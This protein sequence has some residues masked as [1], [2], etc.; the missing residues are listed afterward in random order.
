MLRAQAQT[1]CAEERRLIDRYRDRVRDVPYDK[2]LD[3]GR[4]LPEQLPDNGRQF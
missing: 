2:R 4:T 1:A 3:V